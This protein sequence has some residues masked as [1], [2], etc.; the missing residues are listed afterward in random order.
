MS[1]ATQAETAEDGPDPEHRAKVDAFRRLHWDWLAAVAA[2][3]D[4]DA[5]GDDK[6][7]GALLGKQDAAEMALLTTPAPTTWGVWIKW[8]ILDHLVTTDIEDGHLVEN[9]VIVALGAIK[10]D[11]LRFGLQ[12]RE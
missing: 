11:I 12:D 2:Y 1:D 9:R 4:P 3:H 8:E 10:A 7:M 5:P 6:H